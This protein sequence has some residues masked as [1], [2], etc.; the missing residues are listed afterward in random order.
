MR[1]RT[2]APCAKEHSEKQCCGAWLCVQGFWLWHQRPQFASHLPLVSFNHDRNHD[3]SLPLEIAHITGTV[4]GHV[5]LF[6]HFGTTTNQ[7]I[8]EWVIEFYYFES[9]LSENLRTFSNKTA[10]AFNYV[11]PGIDRYLPDIDGLF[12]LDGG[13]LNS[14]ADTYP[15]ADFC[16]Q[17]NFF[18]L[19]KSSF[20]E[21]ELSEDCKLT[22]HV[23]SST[24]SLWSHEKACLVDETWQSATLMPNHF[25]S[26]FFG[27]QTKGGY[28]P[29]CSIQHCT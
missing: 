16:C 24:K 29:V 23:C 19:R 13:C 4:A 1:S 7:L 22:K 12:S 9:T 27:F 14:E 2:L 3:L 10:T 28:F 8:W 21:V 26:V 6:C 11:L 20:S 25:L 5:G 15:T 18:L 17:R